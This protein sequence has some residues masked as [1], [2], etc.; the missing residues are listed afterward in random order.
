MVVME[1]AKMVY[2][3]NKCLNS[4]KNANIIID[5]FKKII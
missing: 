1:V 4:F 3:T 5:E 2:R